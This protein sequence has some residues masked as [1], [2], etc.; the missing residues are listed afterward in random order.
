MANWFKISEFSCP[1]CGQNHISPE[2]VAML[3]RARTESGVPFV[4]NSGYRCNKH[5]KEIKGSKKSSHLNGL[6]VDIR[7][8]DNQ[9]RDRILTGLFAAN[10]HRIGIADTFIHADIDYSKLASCWL[11]R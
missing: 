6:A 4:I 1:C 7:C 5:N 11:Y 9:E 8:R 10:F 3:Q 2:L